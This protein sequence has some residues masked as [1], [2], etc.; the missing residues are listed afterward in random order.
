MYFQWWTCHF[1]KQ[2]MSTFIKCR[3]CVPIQKPLS[4]LL[5][6]CRNASKWQF[7]WP[8]RRRSSRYTITSL[9]FFMDSTR[10]NCRTNA[11]KI[12]TYN[13]Q[14]YAGISRKKKLVSAWADIYHYF[15]YM[16]FTFF[17][18]SH[19]FHKDTPSY[20]DLFSVGCYHLS[21]DW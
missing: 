18:F 7:L 3:C 9:Q 20:F 5:I 11:R 13:T 14:F 21:F 17:I 2:L 6:V 10:L 12:T 19:Q 4:H 8:I 1:W 15:C 16:T